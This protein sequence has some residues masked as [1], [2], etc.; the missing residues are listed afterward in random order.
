MFEFVEN[1]GE[2]STFPDTIF[3]VISA[4]PAIL[5]I[6]GIANI[7]ER[8]TSGGCART[9]MRRIKEGNSGGSCEGEEKGL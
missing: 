9:K 3:I 1:Y 8:C 2:S 7:R 6:L 5:V 4:R